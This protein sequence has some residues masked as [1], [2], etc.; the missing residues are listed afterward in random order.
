[1]ITNDANVLVFNTVVGI[2]LDEISHISLRN[3][4]GEYFRKAVTSITV[5][6][7]T[8]R[9]F[10]FFINENEGND[11]IVEIG[12]HGNGATATL[13]TGT[14]YATNA[15]VTPKNDTQSLT[16]DWTLEVR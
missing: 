9:V 6:N 16:I 11:N 15:L 7:S 4:S 5:L 3:S 8:R 13:N 1:M 14:T 2:T 12:L 10:T